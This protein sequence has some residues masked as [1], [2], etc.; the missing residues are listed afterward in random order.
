MELLELYKNLAEERKKVLDHTEKLLIEK[1]KEI[2]RL[3]NTINEKC[4]KY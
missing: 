2:E 1:E 4:Y 3:R